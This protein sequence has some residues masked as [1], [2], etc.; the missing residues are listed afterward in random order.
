M[1][2]NVLAMGQLTQDK[3]A[4]I[5]KLNLI[6]EEKPQ[7]EQAKRAKEMLDIIQSGYS[8][9]EELDFNKKYF[10]EYVSD[11]PQ[12]V[13]VLLD[14]EDDTDFSKGA[15][16]D[17]AVKKFKSSKL[18]VSSKI[19]L[20]EKS[21]ILVQEFA[22]I[23]LANKF[24]DAYKAGFEFIDDLQDNKIYIITQENLK[25]LIETAKFEEYKLFYLDN[26]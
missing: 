9:N 8:K 6:I 14:E 17:F 10:F 16:S 2:L 23:T 5:P 15:I 19:T 25:K 22:S 3:S 26:Y 12:Y 18:R 4:L 20:S 24:I 1:L 21:F 7:T 11:V 13:I